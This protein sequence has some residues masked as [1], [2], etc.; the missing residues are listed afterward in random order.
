MAPKGS[1][2]ATN[3]E[4]NTTDVPQVAQAVT[5]DGRASVASDGH[6]VQVDNAGTAT[7]AEA[8][9]N[10]GD[11]S[12]DAIGS[13]I[14]GATRP[15]SEMDDVVPGATRNV[16]PRVTQQTQALALPLP[17]A[18]V[19]TMWQVSSGR[20]DGWW[21]DCSAPFASALEAQFQQQIPV[22]KF[23]FFGNIRVGPIDYTHDLV[24]CQQLNH[25]TGE[26]KQ[27]RRS[28]V[29]LGS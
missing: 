6:A 19:A 18:R 13:A 15:A 12:R 8:A 11:D 16:R 1:N 7:Q 17:A 25:H 27:I 9:A 24:Q 5:T 29:T 26:Y 23:A 4:T 10:P 21:T 3:E 2:S 14:A 22:A 20:V 28:I